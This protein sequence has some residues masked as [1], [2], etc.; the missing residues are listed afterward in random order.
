MQPPEPFERAGWRPHQPARRSIDTAVRD[1]QI[2]LE[3]GLVPSPTEVS[4]VR[5]DMGQMPP[6][7]QGKGL[8]GGPDVLWRSIP[9]Q[10]CLPTWMLL[11]VTPLMGDVGSV[12]PNVVSPMVAEGAP[13]ADRVDKVLIDSVGVSPLATAGGGGSLV[14][15]GCRC[16]TGGS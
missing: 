5:R 11:S 7:G 14:C 12:L 2:V 10:W 1:I 15:C 4:E 8:R 16:T 3:S 13:L 9:R 6:A